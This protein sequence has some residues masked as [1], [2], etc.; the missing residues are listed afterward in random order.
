[1][2]MVLH[3]PITSFRGYY[4]WLSN[5][6]KLPF[7]YKGV[8]YPTA[9]HAYQAAKSSNSAWAHVIGEASTPALA[10]KLGCEAPMWNNWDD[11]KVEEMTEILRE[12]F[13]I[14]GLRKLLVQTAPRE[15]IEGNTWGDTFWGVCRGEGANHLGQCLMKVRQEIIDAEK[16]ID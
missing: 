5:F 2:R 15:L 11:I 10:K 3:E 13:K 8:T 14:P 12:K 9:E 4:G 6:Y 16:G 1:M 7:D